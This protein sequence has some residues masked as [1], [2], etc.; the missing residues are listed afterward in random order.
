MTRDIDINE[1]TCLPFK[2]IKPGNKV[3]IVSK[4]GVT[5]EGTI[6]SVDCGNKIIV[7]DV[8]YGYKYHPDEPYKQYVGDKYGNIKFIKISDIKSIKKIQ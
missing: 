3:K 5:S 6:I 8:E 4:R 7:A 2:N 1:G